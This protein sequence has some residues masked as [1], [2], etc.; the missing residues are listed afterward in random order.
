MAVASLWCATPSGAVVQ[1]GISY[2]E[3]SG[4]IYA[5]TDVGAGYQCA[6]DMFPIGAGVLHNSGSDVLLTGLGYRPKVMY[7]GGGTPTRLEPAEM[8]AIGAALQDGFDL[9]GLAQWSME[10]TPNDLDPVKVDTM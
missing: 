5:G 9:S 2:T 3:D 1:A 4:T 8:R 10:T 7:W 6:G